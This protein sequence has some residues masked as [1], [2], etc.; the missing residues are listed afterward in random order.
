MAARKQKSCAV[1]EGA[2]TAP[3]YS[4]TH[5]HHSLTR[6]H[7]QP[8][9]PNPLTRIAPASA[10]M[11]KTCGSSTLAAACIAPFMSIWSPAASSSC[12]QQQQHRKGVKHAM[13]HT[14]KEVAL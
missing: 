3:P 7:T 10:S 1:T 11:P 4:P 13:A 12:G 5:F 9:S 2:C 8:A 14:H 6:P